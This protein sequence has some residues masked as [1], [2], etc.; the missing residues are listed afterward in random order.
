VELYVERQNVPI[1]AANKMNQW[2]SLHWAAKRGH[3]HVVQYLLSRGADE[4][5]KSSK[6]QMAVD[7]AA[8]DEVKALFS[9]A[10]IQSGDKTATP[11]TSSVNPPSNTSSALTTSAP[12][13]TFVPNYLQ[14][15]DLSK[16]W[17][18]PDL[19]S[20]SNGSGSGAPSGFEFTR[21]EPSRPSLSSAPLPVVEASNSVSA[22]QNPIGQSQSVSNG[23]VV[24]GPML[25]NAL[26]ELM[27]YG[28]FN[29]II[30]PVIALFVRQD[31]LLE[32]TINQLHDEVDYTLERL[33]VARI[34]E[35]K[36]I[37]IHKKQYNQKTWMHFKTG[38]IMLVR[39]NVVFTYNG[40][41]WRVN[42]NMP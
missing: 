40:S 20:S 18:L 12:E 37:P 5:L 33:E 26:R 23:N 19:P 8:T 13:K 3:A 15:P 11:S 22:L 42:I 34:S 41:F 14:N 9:N 31:A 25:E 24:I 32:D 39:G 27:I 29:G 6:G 28:E 1:N 7:V 36:V 10:S 21:E 30:R 4:S 38:D 17:G 2:T 35:G 16:T